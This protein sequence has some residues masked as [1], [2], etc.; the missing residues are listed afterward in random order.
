MKQ[1]YCAHAV[2][3]AL[4][5]AKCDRESDYLNAWEDGFAAARA[6]QA[7]RDWLDGTAEQWQAEC[8]QA[9]REGC[10]RGVEYERHDTHYLHVQLKELN[11]RHMALIKRVAE[12]QSMLPPR[13]LIVSDPNKVTP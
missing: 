13:V 2:P 5:C 6:W 1:M 7:L 11:D 8:N 4:P 3:I 10:D 9:Y 12:G